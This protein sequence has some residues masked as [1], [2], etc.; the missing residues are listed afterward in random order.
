MKNNIHPRDSKIKFEEEGHR[1]TIGDGSY[2]YIS[3]TS[4]V[5]SLFPSFNPDYVIT[6]M[7]NGPNWNPT[8]KYYGLTDDEI[9]EQWRNTSN[10]AKNEGTDFHKSIEQ[11]L[12]EELQQEPT[13]KEWELFKEF[14][15]KHEGTPYR[16]EWMIFD[17]YNL[18]CGT[19]DYITK[20]MDGTYT[21]IDWKRSKNIFNPTTL[22]ITNTTY[23]H[24][25]IQLN[26]YK[27]ILERYYSIVIS[28]MLIVQIHPD[29]G[30]RVFNIPDKQDYIKK[31]LRLRRMK[32]LKDNN[33][34]ADRGE[35]ESEESDQ[36]I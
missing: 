12:K 20:N 8:N 28:K 16:S 26:L 10:N 30:L 25:T 7:K 33:G 35:S 15:N 24:Y 36:A 9:K 31:C 5:K 22:F 4:F 3:V 18:V 23:W 34:K 29:T 21:I 14:I 19:L 11:Y 17:E 6:K 13:S 32:L 1:Y 2:S 27:H